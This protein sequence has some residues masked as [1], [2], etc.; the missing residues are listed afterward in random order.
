MMSSF[1]FYMKHFEHAVGLGE[2]KG[3]NFNIVFYFL[4][5]FT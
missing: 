3:Q 4:F 2:F 1:G 5:F